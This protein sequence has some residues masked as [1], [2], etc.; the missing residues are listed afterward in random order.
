MTAQGA[1]REPAG[2]QAAEALRR[3]VLAA[4]REARQNRLAERHERLAAETGLP[5]HRAMA[6]T[7]RKVAAR[8][9][10]AAGL[11][12]SF[13][14]RAIQWS[15]GRGA[16]PLFMT[17]V[18][19][20]CGTRSAALTLVGVDHGQLA[21]AASDRL[22]R[23]AQDLEFVLGTGPAREAASAGLPVVAHG[24]DIDLRWPGY[25]VGL[26]GLGLSAVA[27]VP[28]SVPSG[29]I[30]ALTVFDPRPGLTEEGTLDEVAAALAD[31][32]LLGAEGEPDLYGGAD[33]RAVVHQA[34]GVLSEQARCSVADALE[35]I[36]ARA[37][38]GGES[39]ESVA[40]RI[41]S[42]ELRLQAGPF[43]GD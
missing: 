27:S 43:G 23:Q 37:F 22:A 1:A 4:A 21:V 38:T 41:V 32:V 14:R 18:A 36:K 15:A 17:E 40:E 12:E 34:A 6:E 25:G 11:Q 26:T 5:I 30:G 7:H 31:G 29:C 20:A 16:R 42:G 9:R 13:A 35:L 24:A 8:H 10:A 19:N 33:L 2:N 3:A 39:A 28:L